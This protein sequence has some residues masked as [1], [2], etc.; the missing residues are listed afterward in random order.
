[1]SHNQLSPAQLSDEE[2]GR[3]VAAMR[4]LLIEC[5]TDMKTPELLFPVFIDAM[6]TLIHTS[7]VKAGWWSDIESGQPKIRNVPEILA[8]AHS[9]ISEAL[10]GFRKN[11]PDDKLPHRSMLEVEIADTLIRLL[12]LAGSRIIPGQGAVAD[13][14][15][16]AEGVRMNL[17]ASLTEKLLFNRTREDHQLE[18]RRGE[19]GK[20][21]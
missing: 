16:T 8:L 20:K 13:T 5:V 21:I 14:P 12:D 15:A 6:V 7:N 2:D 4:V 17:G 10:E 19:H 3:L 1:M 11:L 18:H 9:E